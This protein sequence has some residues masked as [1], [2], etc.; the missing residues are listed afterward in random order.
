MRFF[1]KD[2]P[3]RGVAQMGSSHGNLSEVLNELEGK[4]CFVKE[5]TSSCVWPLDPEGRIHRGRPYSKCQLLLPRHF[6]RAHKM[7]NISR[8]C[9]VVHSGNTKKSWSLRLS[10][11]PSRGETAIISGWGQFVTD[12]GV[13]K[14]DRLVFSLTAMPKFRV[15]IFDSNG[16]PKAPQM[17]QPS[18]FPTEIKVSRRIHRVLESLRNKREDSTAEGTENLV[19]MSSVPRSKRKAISD[20]ESVDLTSN[21]ASLNTFHRSARPTKAEIVEDSPLKTC[22][23]CSYPFKQDTHVK[24]EPLSKEEELVKEEI[25]FDRE[26]F[27]MPFTKKSKE[28]TSDRNLNLSQKSKIHAPPTAEHLL[29]TASFQKQLAKGNLSRMV[30][31][32]AYPF[33]FCCLRKQKIGTCSSLNVKSNSE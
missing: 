12:N 24:K 29:Q 5:M 32:S 11:Y 3:E 21:A 14:G 18:S 4:M 33:E 7:V 31:S 6:A 27:V 23:Q 8:I 1:F 30:S 22:A 28:G 15:Y 9:V 2:S 26:E 13:A 20:D 25:L 17:L 19:S 10:H 16:L